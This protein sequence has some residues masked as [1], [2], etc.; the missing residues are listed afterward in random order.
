MEQKEWLILLL[1]FVPGAGCLS[2][3][4]TRRRWSICKGTPGAFAV[5]AIAS[6]VPDVIGVRIGGRAVNKTVPNYRLATSSL[7]GNAEKSA[8]NAASKILHNIYDNPKDRKQAGKSND[9]LTEGLQDTRK[10]QGMLSENQS[11]PEAKLTIDEQSFAKRVDTLV[12]GERGDTELIKVLTTPLALELV[13]AEM[14]PIEITS[15]N[16]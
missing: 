16:T 6:L 8:A 2:F 9:I 12:S 4:T 7:L 5:D 3:F 15:K 13:G 14:L 10:V 11:L 1:N